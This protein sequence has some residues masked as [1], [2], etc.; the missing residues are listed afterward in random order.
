[1][2]II[3]GLWESNPQKTDPVF[4]TGL[5]LSLRGCNGRFVPTKTTERETDGEW[6]C[7]RSTYWGFKVCPM[8]LQYDALARAWELVRY[9][10]DEG[11]KSIFNAQVHPGFKNHPCFASWPAG[12]KV[13]TEEPRFWETL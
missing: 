12:I 13:S 1:M 3:G 4:V 5:P 10:P 6:T 9:T 7:E 2:E 11:W 8:M